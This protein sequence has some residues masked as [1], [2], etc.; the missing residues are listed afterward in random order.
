[1]REGET[2]R[3]PLQWRWGDSPAP[4][5]RI[6]AQ[7]GVLAVPSESSYGLAADPRSAASVAA[8]YQLKERPADKPLLVV[9]A[10][11]EQ[12]AGLGVRAP[13]PALDQLAAV[14]PAALTAVLPLEQ[15]L[16]ASCGAA[17][18]AVRVPAHR[19]LRGLLRQLGPVTST[20]ANRAGEAPLCRSEEVHEWLAQRDVGRPTAVVDDGELPGGPPSTVVAWER[21]GWR[22]LRQGAVDWPQG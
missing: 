5:Q 17:S 15:A 22:L 14:W 11:V 13:Q 19:R 16:P 1:M 10:G 9:L 8:I 3:S 21:Q 12:L 6:L 7:E 2:R 4:L 18:L 20:S